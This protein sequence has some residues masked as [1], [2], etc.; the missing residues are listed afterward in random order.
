MMPRGC[1]LSAMKLLF[2]YS[3]PVAANIPGVLTL[4]EGLSSIDVLF[5]SLD[6][7]KVKKVPGNMGISLLGLCWKRDGNI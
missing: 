5:R 2:V 1:A 7:I 6:F 4:V 3:K